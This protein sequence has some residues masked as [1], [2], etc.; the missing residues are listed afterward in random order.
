MEKRSLFKMKD[1]PRED[2]AFYVE[3][4]AAAAISAAIVLLA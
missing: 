2:K 1:V 3:M 4:A